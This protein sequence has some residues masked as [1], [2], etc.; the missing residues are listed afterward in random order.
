MFINSGNDVSAREEFDGYINMLTI[1]KIIAKKSSQGKAQSKFIIV[2]RH[3]S[4]NNFRRE[5]MFRCPNEQIRDEWVDG[6]TKYVTYFQ[7][8][9][10]FF[11]N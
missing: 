6:L 4:E 8:M 5:F 11:A 7:Q 1:E 2:G 3:G 9:Q 10:D